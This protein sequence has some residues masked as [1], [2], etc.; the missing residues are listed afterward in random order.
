MGILPMLPNERR[1]ARRMR[2]RRSGPVRCAVL[3]AATLLALAG[4]KRLGLADRATSLLDPAD[5]VPAVGQGAIAITTR[6]GEAD[7]AALLAPILDAGTGLALRCERALLRVLD[8]SCRTPIGGFAQVEGGAI[9]LHAIIL[10]PDGSQFFET[11]L[12]GATNEAESLGE[13]AART[14][15]AQAPVGFFAA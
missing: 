6:A 10:L 13:S 15:L 3:A 4:L 1:V 2:P 14:L 5:F 9:A 11:K 7:V 8:G 12:R